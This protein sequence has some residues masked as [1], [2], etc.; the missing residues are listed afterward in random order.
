M[1]SLTVAQILA[2]AK[3]DSVACF[4]GSIIRKFPRISNESEHGPYSFE[5]VIVVDASNE[6]MKVKL[7]DRE[8]LPPEAT[9]LY[10]ACTE[11]DKKTPK[12]VKV[13]IYE[14]KYNL[15]T[16]GW[17]DVKIWT[18]DKWVDLP[19]IVKRPKSETA[20]KPAMSPPPPVGAPAQGP[21]PTAK[22]NESKKEPAPP[23]SAPAD[24]RTLAEKAR[25]LPVNQLI[26]TR[27]A[28]VK[29]A[30]DIVNT[31]IQAGKVDLTSAPITEKEVAALVEN[32]AGIFYN[33]CFDLDEYI[34]FGNRNS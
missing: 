12:G 11:D 20:A 31:L 19:K 32:Y 28:C 13:D 3:G 29:S 8:P 14:G 10:V 23:A 5:N 26:I 18:C 25:A 4:S 22:P 27:S 1:D 17:S 2:K 16:N 9:G 7:K 24:T 30:V 15:E 6:Q 21:A 34:P 33:L